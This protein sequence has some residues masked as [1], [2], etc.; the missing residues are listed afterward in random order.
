ML[1]QT[2]F[3]AL[4]GM[5]AS[6]MAGDWQVKLGASAL[7]PQNDD[8]GTLNVPVGGVVTPLKAQVSNEV[9]FTPSVEYFFNNSHFSR[10]I[11]RI[12]F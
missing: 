5:S 4:L 3:I 8:N 9:N 1:K 2:A 11:A 7:A 6:A 12:T 10:V